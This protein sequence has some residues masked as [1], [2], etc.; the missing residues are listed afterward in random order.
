VIAFLGDVEAINWLKGEPRLLQRKGKIDG[1]DEVL[2]Q[3]FQGWTVSAV[4]IPLA[5][6]KDPSDIHNKII[7]K[8]LCEDLRLLKVQFVQN[9]LQ[10]VFNLDD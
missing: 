5:E 2:Y 1:V 6:S 8:W 9:R 4:A 7:D 10:I 3:G